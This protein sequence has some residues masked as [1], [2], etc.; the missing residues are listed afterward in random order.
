MS[1][2]NGRR[3]VGRR[4]QFRG[5]TGV[6][7]DAGLESRGRSEVRRLASPTHLAVIPIGQKAG[8][9]GSG[10]GS[11][12]L[13]IRARRGLP[14]TFSLLL[15]RTLSRRLYLFF[16]LR[17][18]LPLAS[19]LPPMS[20]LL[21]LSASLFPA[22]RIALPPASSSP[23]PLLISSDPFRSP[24]KAGLENDGEVRDGAK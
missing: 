8:K 5:G 15:P 11:R 20:S 6:G 4:R 16:S 17:P 2:G 12:A 22:S 21:F 3:R 10:I 23:S 18:L 13:S 14:F 24:L 19:F 7:L 1:E 9:S